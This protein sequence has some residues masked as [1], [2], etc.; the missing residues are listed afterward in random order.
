MKGKDLATF[1]VSA[2][3]FEDSVLLGCDA[4]LLGESR[5]FRKIVAPLSST[6][7]SLNTHP[8][9]SDDLNTLSHPIICMK[10]LEKNMKSLSQWSVSGARL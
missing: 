8:S 5:R 9:M 1:E 4:I 2:D 7:E 6:C 3:V 10:G